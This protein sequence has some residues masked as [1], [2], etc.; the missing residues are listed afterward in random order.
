[1]LLAFGLYFVLGF[2]LYALIYAAAG[3]VVTR[4]EDLQV[5]ALPLSL[6]AVAG[7][8]QA[9]LALIAGTA[10]F[11]R[12]ASFVPF[13]SPFVMLTRIS[14]GRVELWEI[15]LSLALL[16]ATIPIVLVVAIRIYTAGVLMYGQRPGLRQFVA[17][18]LGR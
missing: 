10:G 13:W 3:S 17:A 7:Y 16:A 2:T 9:L 11:V 14:V 12:F 5:I 8:A 4:L 15:V 1:M 18:A 6:L